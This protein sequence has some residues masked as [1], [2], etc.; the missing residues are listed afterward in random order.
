MN[1][2]K[3]DN[4]W[5]AEWNDEGSHNTV[6]YFSTQKDAFISCLVDWK[7]GYDNIDHYREEYKVKKNKF[8]KWHFLDKYR[9]LRRYNIYKIE[10]NE[11]FLTKEDVELK[12]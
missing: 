2:G 3:D 9:D 10:V 1:E 12:E 6:G 5:V 4:I 11:S 8:Y 7:Y